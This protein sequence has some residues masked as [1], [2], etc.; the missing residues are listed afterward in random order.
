MNSKIKLLIVADTYYPKV[1]GTL[2]FIEEFVKR[3]H[4]EFDISLLVPNLGKST[5]PKGVKDVN[6]IAPSRIVKLSG[7]PN[8]KISIKN[9]CKIKKAVK[10]ADFVFVQGPALIS[11]LSIY[12]GKKYKKKIIFYKHH[13]TWEL[14]EN[15]FPEFS[16]KFLIRI[17]RKLAIIFYNKC[18]LIIIPYRELEDSLKQYGVNSEI[19]VGSLGIDIDQFSISKN[20]KT[21]KKK[22]KLPLNKTI[23][24]YVGRISKEKNI[25][26]LLEAFKKVE[27]KDIFLLIVGDGNP[28]LVKKIKEIR[29][30]H[31]TGFV[32]NVQDYLKAM[33]VFV[34]PSLTETTSLATLEAMSC[35]LPVIATKV[36][37]IKNYLVK[38]HNG[39]FFPRNSSTM[40]ALKIEQLIKDP[41]LMKTLGHNARK[42]V[43]YSFSW[44]RSVNKI[45]R[46]LLE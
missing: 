19:K 10:K 26:I 15:F 39:I 22:L 24:G 8:M 45:K 43:A 31:V 41:E 20:K 21:S 25:D 44:D 1:D 35:G 12:Y 6:L 5:K 13:I 38:D 17:V 16:K 7:Y 23:I 28:E 30:C 9:I 29:N 32:N 18:N 3:T 42:M 40:L 34:M 46:I 27:S 37:F 2:R 36:G 14:Y 33:D 4:N 11:Y